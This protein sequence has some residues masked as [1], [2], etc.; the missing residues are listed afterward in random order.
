MKSI[1][2]KN[3]FSQLICLVLFT[4]LLTNC[5]E[6]TKTIKENG[7]DYFPLPLG[8]S[9]IYDIDSFLYDGINKRIDSTK[10]VIK[11]EIV[12]LIV[13]STGQENYRIERSLLLDSITWR[14]FLSYTS[15][16]RPL[17]LQTLKDNHREV[18]MS[19]PITDLK[20][21]D[22]NLYSSRDFQEFKYLG[23]QE[24]F[25]VGEM[26]FDN[27]IT[28]LH[29]EFYEPKPPLQPLFDIYKKEVFAKGVGLIYRVDRDLDLQDDSGYEIILRLK[30]YN[31]K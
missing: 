3:G 8:S 14:P 22:G 23:I 26:F 15:A 16:L 13:D 4:L 11:D 18:R 25:E 5:K 30:D 6:E 28:V 29:K 20:T 12:E 17:S 10:Q 7:Q 31:I 1:F 27:T 21:W 24:G 19:F 2:K 9:Y